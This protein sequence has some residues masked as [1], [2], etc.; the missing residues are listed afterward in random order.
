MKP[1]GPYKSKPLPGSFA[2]LILAFYASGTYRDWAPATLRKNDRFLRGLMAESGRLMVADLGRGD[3]VRMRDSLGDTPATAANWLKLMRVLL[4]YAIDLGLVEVNVA[5]GVKNPRQK[6]AGGFR[7]W[8]EHEIAAFIERW[9]LGTLPHRVMTLALYTGAARVDLVKLGWGN[10]REGHL[11]F[12]RHKMRRDE[13]EV[14]IDLVVDRLPPLAEL[15]R[16]IP[17]HC[18]TF[19]ETAKGL[20]RSELSLTN[21]MA[22]WTLKAGLGG[23]DENG[24]HLNMHGLR[25]A[26]GR[27]LAEGGCSPHQIMAVLGH[28]N[29]AS[30]TPYTKAYDRKKAAEGAA[31]AMTPKPTNVTKLVRRER[32]SDGS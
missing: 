8:Q 26:V 11:R 13:E 27:R 7:S 6:G 18:L 4:D 32:I 20:Q 23:A 5:R 29:I 24:R 17:K 28:R 22:L 16:S 10:I 3:V 2:D 30:V 19:L 31:D 1:R 9:P 14:W 25:K 21:D 15:L 12:Q